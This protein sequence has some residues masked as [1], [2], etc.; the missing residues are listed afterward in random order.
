MHILA[1]RVYCHTCQF[2]GTWAPSIT[3]LFYFVRWS[4]KNVS[5]LLAAFMTALLLDLC[6]QCHVFWM[7]VIYFLPF[8]FITCHVFRWS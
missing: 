4:A 6:C 8:E 5:N 1:L 3:A 2:G 7:V